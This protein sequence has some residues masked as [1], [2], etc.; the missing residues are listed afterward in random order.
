M[1]EAFEGAEFRSVAR[2]TKTPIGVAER[3]I[4]GR[5]AQNAEVLSRR[6]RFSF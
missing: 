4:L 3:R 2:R 5:L 6:S 1:I